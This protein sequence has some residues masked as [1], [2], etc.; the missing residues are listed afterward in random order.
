MH[1]SDPQTELGLKVNNKKNKKKVEGARERIENRENDVLGKRNIERQTRDS[2]KKA[3]WG[4]FTTS[5]PQNSQGVQIPQGDN[6]MLIWADA[7]K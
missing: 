7:E 4:D 1:N 6:F 2:F 3:V 5:V